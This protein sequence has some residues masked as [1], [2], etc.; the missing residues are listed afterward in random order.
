MLK[1]GLMRPLKLI[2]RS[3]IS[4]LMCVYLSFTYGILYLLFTSMPIV[5]AQQYAWEPEITGL[6]YLGIGSGFF[7]GLAVTHGSHE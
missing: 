5:F 1:R 2:A 7:I 6:A 4:A 3:P